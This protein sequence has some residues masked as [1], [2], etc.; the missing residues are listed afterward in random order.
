MFYIIKM[1][2]TSEEISTSQLDESPKKF[3]QGKGYSVFVGGLGPSAT[4]EM[5]IA[6]FG[7]FGA[8]DECKV[9]TW[10]KKKQEEGSQVCKGFGFIRCSD[11]AVFER[12]LQAEHWIGG[13]LVECKREYSSEEEAQQESQ[14]LKRKKVF[15]KNLPPSITSDQLRLIF[16]QFGEVEIAY[17]T[18][19]RKKTSKLGFVTFKT[20]EAAVRATAQR[21]I[22][23]E[24]GK[25]LECLP[26]MTR[27]EVRVAGKGKS[28]PAEHS[29]LPRETSSLVQ[30]PFALEDSPR[31]PTGGEE[32]EG[33]GR[34]KA[35]GFSAA[36]KRIYSGLV[37]NLSTRENLEG[38][39][40]FLS[41]EN[42]LLQETQ[43]DH[44][45]KHPR[46]SE[47]LLSELDIFSDFGEGPSPKKSLEPPRARFDLPDNTSRFLRT[48]NFSTDRRLDKSIDSSP[49]QGSIGENLPSLLDQL[50]FEGNLDNPS[51]PAA[52]IPD[53]KRSNQTKQSFSVTQKKVRIRSINHFD[54]K[55]Q[56][57]IGGPYQQQ[58]FMTQG[59]LYREENWENNHERDINQ[60]PTLDLLD[61][62][63][64]RN[65]QNLQQSYQLPQSQSFS[66]FP[67][68]KHNHG[69]Q[70]LGTEPPQMLGSMRGP[71]LHPPNYTRVNGYHAPPFNQRIR[72]QEALQF[73]WGGYGFSHEAIRGQ[74]LRRGPIL[75]KRTMD[76]NKLAD[77]IFSMNKDE[78]N[79]RFNVQ[80]SP[81][82]RIRASTES[83]MRRNGR[84]MN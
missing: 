68:T 10:K 44:F 15:I 65:P 25:P 48:R 34:T 67:L 46:S 27:K 84:R 71:P 8:I 22:A 73:P 33:H 21:L 74:N 14:A 59:S 57:K 54:Q 24:I 2:N 66:C 3:A 69:N 41:H 76:P 78:R 30:P 53:Q 29:H 70:Y 40:K 49:S 39:I 51:L 43:Q 47:K 6:H 26:Y 19:G 1:I 35:G 38:E 31:N 13:R 61:D 20:Q 42:P 56:K 11:H 16:E 72:P 4:D 81:T 32:G 23:T 50:K 17:T 18:S 58:K 28:S 45:S 12:I 64:F 80:Y 77:L 9:Q 60:I 5:L 83:R 82:R 75:L 37:G 36:E 79:M 7:K 55:E 52:L 63:A 62:L